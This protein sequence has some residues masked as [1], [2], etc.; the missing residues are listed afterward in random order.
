MFVNF[1]FDSLPG[2]WISW[3]NLLLPSHYFILIVGTRLIHSVFPAPR[4]FLFYVFCLLSFRILLIWALMSYFL[5]YEF[6]QLDTILNFYL[7]LLF[8]FGK[9]LHRYFLENFEFPN[10]SIT[11]LNCIF[12]TTHESLTSKMLYFLR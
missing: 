7:D 4:G 2:L 3:S 1:L 9:I 11:R 12:V 8:K 10:Q 5:I 6:I